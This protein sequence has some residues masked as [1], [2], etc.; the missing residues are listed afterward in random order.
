MYVIS[1]LSSSNIQTYADR[2]FIVRNRVD[3]IASGSH[4]LNVQH[5]VRDATK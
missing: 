4:K 5:M 2:C 3:I 1:M